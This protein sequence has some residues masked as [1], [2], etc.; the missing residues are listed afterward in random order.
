LGYSQTG[1]IFETTLGRKTGALKMVALYK[2]DNKLK[3]LLN[4]I[5]ILN[6]S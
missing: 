3:E 6:I 4:E 2:D 5:T 1:T